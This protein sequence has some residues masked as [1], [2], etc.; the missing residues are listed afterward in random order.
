VNKGHAVKYLAEKEEKE[1]IIA[2]GDSV[3]DLDML[4]NTKHFISPQH[5]DIYN[6]KSD[7]YDKKMIKFTKNHGILAGNEI[8]E[9]VLKMCS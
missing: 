2:A 3:L 9:T 8:L 4:H 6:L 5:G 7:K 1:N